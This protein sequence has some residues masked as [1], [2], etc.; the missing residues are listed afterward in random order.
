[1]VGEHCFLCVCV[2][3]LRAVGPSFSA[4]TPSQSHIAAQ[5]QA[6]SHLHF[7]PSTI[8]N[9][10]FRSPTFNAP[11]TSRIDP[12]KYSTTFRITLSSESQPVQSSRASSPLEH[13][14]SPPA[15]SI[16]HGKLNR[17]LDISI[18]HPTRSHFVQLEA[19]GLTLP[20]SHLSLSPPPPIKYNY[21]SPHALL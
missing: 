15:N 5:Q 8:L 2:R 21:L 12:R 9:S 17:C 16:C 1:M 19:A 13:Q 7:D 6:Q 20:V 3:S 4:L 10:G 14:H 18:L 11:S